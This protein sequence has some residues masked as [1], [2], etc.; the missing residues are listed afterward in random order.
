MTRTNIDIDDSAVEAVMTRYHFTTKK[1]AVNFALRTVA[2]EAMPLGQA[3]A[4][5]GTGW[6]GDLD[7]MR[8]TRTS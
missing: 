7:G 1:D 5:R 6:E 8:E 3:R 4:M 2:A